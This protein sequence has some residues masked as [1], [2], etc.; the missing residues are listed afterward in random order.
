M[1]RY[2]GDDGMTQFISSSLPRRWRRLPAFH[3]PIG[4]E[5]DFRHCRF[6]IENVVRQISDQGNDD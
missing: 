1:K 2:E 5:Q 3:A 6:A 4:T